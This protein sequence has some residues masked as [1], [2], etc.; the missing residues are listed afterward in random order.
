MSEI[1]KLMEIDSIILTSSTTWTTM[2]LPT[3]IY[4][5]SLFNDPSIMNNT[6]HIDLND[7]YITNAGFIQVNQWPQTD[8]DLTPKLYVDTE[9]DQSSLVKNNQDNAFNNNNLTH[10]NSITLN[11]QAEMIMKSLLKHA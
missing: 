2:V 7:R 3:K 11:K 9:I 6:A 5:D 1:G 8:S 4:V 10:M